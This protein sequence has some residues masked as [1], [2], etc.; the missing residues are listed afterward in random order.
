MPSLVLNNKRLAYDLLEAVGLLGIWCTFL[1]RWEGVFM[2]KVTRRV[3]QGFTLIELMIVV[4]I[5]GILAAIAIP[6]YQDFLIRSKVSE[7]AAALG[8]CKTSVSEYYAANNAQ[9]PT[10]VSQAGC[11]TV[12]TKFVVNLSVGTAGVITATITGTNN[13]NDPDGNNLTLTPSAGTGT[14]ITV[15]SCTTN[16]TKKYVPATC[17]G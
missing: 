3:Q 10:T 2:N 4:A 17:R 13:A 14:G 15:W 6:A 9:Y 16:A 7:A 1:N 11:S 8:A 5:V 12:P